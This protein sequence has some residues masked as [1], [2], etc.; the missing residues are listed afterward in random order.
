V[1]A[2]LRRVPHRPLVGVEPG[3]ADCVPDARV[4]LVRQRREPRFAFRLGDEVRE[5]LALQQPLPAQDVDA[6][7]DD[8]SL[9]L[10]GC[11]AWG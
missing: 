8:A 11:P 1:L 3:D 4:E 10:P 7:S 9:G 6:H 5:L 2:A